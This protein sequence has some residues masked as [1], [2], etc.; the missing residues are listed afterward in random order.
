MAK[1]CKT[2]FN[3]ESRAFYKKLVI[4]LGIAMILFSFE[5][6]I[7]VIV[8]FFCF[9]AALLINRARFKKT[10]SYW[11]MVDYLRKAADLGH[12]AAKRKL[13]LWG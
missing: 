7:T 11:V 2:V 13:I 9:I 5:K 3:D 12:K 6:M 4:V 10:E 8:E 1:K